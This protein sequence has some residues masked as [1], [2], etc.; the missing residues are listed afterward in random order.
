[1]KR[2]SKCCKSFVAAKY[3]YYECMNCKKRL[4]SKEVDFIHEKR[5]TYA[6]KPPQSTP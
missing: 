4:D 5:K 6:R 2:L 1:M 3:D